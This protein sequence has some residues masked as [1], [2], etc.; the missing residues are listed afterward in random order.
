MPRLAT[1]P[2][3]LAP[4]CFLVVIL[5]VAQPRQASAQMVMS[6]PTMGTVDQTPPDQLPVPQK[7]TGIGNVSMHITASPEAQMWFN[8]GLNL[9]HDFWDYESARAFEQSIRVDPQ[10]AMCFWGLYKAESF[11]HGTS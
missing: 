8:Q 9:I 2:G 6:D 4:F 5:S 11:F 1:F 3:K 7:M 10:C